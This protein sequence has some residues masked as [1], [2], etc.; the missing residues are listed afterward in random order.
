MTDQPRKKGAWRKWWGRRAIPRAAP[1]LSSV[2]RSP[3]DPGNPRLLPIACCEGGGDLG[4]HLARVDGALG[5][6]GRGDRFGS[7]R[8]LLDLHLGLLLLPAARALGAGARTATPAPGLVADGP[9]GHAP[10]PE[11]GERPHLVALE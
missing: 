7:R 10:Q 4:R 5:R 8:V 11:H 3:G 1:A 9:V 2:R 6:G